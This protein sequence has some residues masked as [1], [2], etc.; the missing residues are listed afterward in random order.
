M[1]SDIADRMRANVEAARA[2]AYAYRP[3]FPAREA[4]DDATRCTGAD[5]CGPAELAAR[6]LAEW[7]LQLRQRLPSGTG[8]VAIDG[9]AFV[10]DVWVAW[11]DPVTG[12]QPPRPANECPS[13][14]ADAHPSPRCLHLRVSL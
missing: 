5:A 13:D 8:Y 4:P 6:D 14:Y 12:L 1:A 11:L 10:A 2:G 7:T 3:D 9:E